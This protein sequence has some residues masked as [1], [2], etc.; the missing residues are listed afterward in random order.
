MRLEPV[1]SNPYADPE[2]RQRAAIYAR[3]LDQLAT[4]IHFLTRILPEPD[5]N[6]FASD[7]RDLSNLADALR[8]TFDA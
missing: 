5:A 7:V 4:D 2:A 3:Q 6:D 8:R 1:T